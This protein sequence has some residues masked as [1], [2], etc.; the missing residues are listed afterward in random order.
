MGLMIAITF[1]LLSLLKSYFKTDRRFLAS[2]TSDDFFISLLDKIHHLI[3][4]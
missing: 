2:H 1:L 3:A 4:Q